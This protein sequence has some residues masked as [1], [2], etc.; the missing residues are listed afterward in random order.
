M[1]LNGSS[2][3]AVDA[4]AVAMNGG[5]MLV[6]PGAVVRAHPAHAE[7]DA[8]DHGDAGQHLLELHIAG[9]AQQREVVDE[10]GEGLSDDADNRQGEHR[11][12]LAG[13]AAFGYEVAAKGALRFHCP[14]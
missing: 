1:V 2:F 9:L 6:A 8:E 3:A 12:G 4:S 7:H 10:V 5:I 14:V 13:G 11:R